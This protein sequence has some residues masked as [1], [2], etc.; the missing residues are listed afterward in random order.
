MKGLIIGMG[1]QKYAAWIFL[2]AFWVVALPL[3]TMWVFGFA[4]GISFVWGMKVLGSGICLFGN[5]AIVV[6]TN[7]DKLIGNILHRLDATRTN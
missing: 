2:F 1:L 5:I 6:C 3:S 7:W 4:K